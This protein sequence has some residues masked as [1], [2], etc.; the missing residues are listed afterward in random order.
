MKRPRSTWS[1]AR[2]RPPPTPASGCS[3]T[4]SIPTPSC[5][6]RPRDPWMLDRAV[7]QPDPVVFL[8]TAAD[9][10]EAAA[11][12]RSPEHLFLLME[13]AGVMLRFDRSVTPTMAKM[14]TLAR[15][16]LDRLRTIERVVRLGHVQHVEPGR[17]LLA[18]GDVAIARTP[19]SCTA[20]P[21]DCDTRRWCRSGDPRRSPY[22]RSGPPS[23]VS[24]P[25]WRATSRRHSR[26][27]P[28][29][30]GCARPRRSPTHRRLGAAAG[31]RRPSVLQVASPHQGVGRHGGAQPGTRAGGVGRTPPP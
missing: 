14:P 23:P 21:R 22:S 6:V 12:A 10:L 28:R 7:V 8:G 1:P 5:W 19:W 18:D 4:A 17:L 20:L 11:A 29:R 30:T 16:E 26:T 3:T 31:A 13:E 15:W 25:H 24:V 27:T 9:I 2:G